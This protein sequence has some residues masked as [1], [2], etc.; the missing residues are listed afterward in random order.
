MSFEASARI[1]ASTARR[2]AHICLRASVKALDRRPCFQCAA[3]MRALPSGV[4][5]PVDR[6]PC[7]RQRVLP[8]SGGFWH[9]VPLRVL[10]AHRW[11]GQS[12]PNRHGIRLSRLL[13]VMVK[14]PPFMGF[15]YTPFQAVWLGACGLVYGPRPMLSGYPLAASRLAPEEGRSNPHGNCLLSPL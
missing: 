11:P 5:G 14:S 7:S 3:A 13:F 4:L 1:L 12:G 8:L 10:A 2:S 6:P 9:A 15:Y